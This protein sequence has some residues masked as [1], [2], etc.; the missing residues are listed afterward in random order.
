[1]TPPAALTAYRMNRHHQDDD[2][3]PYG[4]H[5]LGM[6]DGLPV[7][8]ILERAVHDGRPLRLDWGDQDPAGVV[9]DLQPLPKRTPRPVMSRHPVDH[10]TDPELL[11]AIYYGLRKL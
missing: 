2:H 4:R 3:T 5:V 8:G 7:S 9:D 6:P 11:K 10:E 1:M